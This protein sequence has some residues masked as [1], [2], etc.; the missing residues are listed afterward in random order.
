M[1]LY[2]KFEINQIKKGQIVDKKVD[3]KIDK[4]E[5]RKKRTM[6]YFIEA[7]CSI[8]EKDGIPSLSVR[9]VADLAGYHFS[10][11]YS[12]FENLTEVKYYSALRFIDKM[13]EFIT[14]RLK[15]TKFKDPTEHYIA[16]RRTIAD[17]S[18]EHPEAYKLIN[19]ENLGKNY[20]K[21]K[22]D[23][24]ASRTVKLERK[25]FQKC[26]KKYKISDDRFEL[27]HGVILSLYHNYFRGLIEREKDIDFNK[28]IDEYLNQ[29]KHLFEI[30]SP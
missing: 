21:I 14:D 3:K 17:Y 1:V 22:K 10:T 23:F 30:F 6:N 12:Y 19:F 13:Y 28:W 29:I 9:K 16:I 5:L 20:K 7:A 26:I 24:L 4:K 11:L 8:I 15:D 27:L 18:F 2:T 25:T